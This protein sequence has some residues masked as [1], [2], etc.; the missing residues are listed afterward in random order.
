MACSEVRDGHA[1]QILLIEFG[2]GVMQ[3]NQI[4]QHVL[5]IIFLRL[6]PQGRFDALRDFLLDSL[7]AILAMSAIAVG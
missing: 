5:A 1:S 3:L 2:S 6:I 4:R 7:L